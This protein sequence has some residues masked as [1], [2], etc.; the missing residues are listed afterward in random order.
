MRTIIEKQSGVTNFELMNLSWIKMS[1]RERWWVAR[2]VLCRVRNM[3]FRL[4]RESFISLW[5]NG[6]LNVLQRVYSSYQFPDKYLHFRVQTRCAEYTRLN[7]FVTKVLTESVAYYIPMRSRA[8][9]ARGY[10]CATHCAILLAR[11]FW[12]SIV[13]LLLQITSFTLIHFLYPFHIRIDSA[14]Y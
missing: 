8:T 4:H 9:L 10:Q 6:R 13:L 12:P 11:I 2:I 3:G 5:K 1:E 7:G 14:I